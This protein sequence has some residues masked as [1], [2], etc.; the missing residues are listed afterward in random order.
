M[1]R[2]RL[3]LCAAALMLLQS[4]GGATAPV[5]TAPAPASSASKPA[6]ASAALA[7]PA[8]SASSAAKAASS[9]LTKIVA[10]YSNIFA[11]YLPLWLA[12]D[13]GQFEKNG[14]DV[15]TTLIESIKGVPALLSGEVQFAAIGGPEQLA[16]AAN[17]G[18]VAVITV[19]QPTS[20]YVLMGP[21]SMKTVPDLKG[22]KLGISSIG[23]A[24]D[25]STR[26]A[27]LK[28]GLDPDKDVTIVPVGSLTNR[29]AA[30]INGATDAGIAQVPETLQL[31]DKG[32]RTLVDLSQTDLPGVGG[33]VITRRS[34]TQDHRDVVQRYVDAHIAAVRIAK[35]DRART[36][37]T[38]KKYM[39][40]DDEKQLNA[41]YEFYAVKYLPALPAPR[42]D[43]FVGAQQIMGAKDDKVRNYNRANFIDDSFV[44][45]A[46]AR[47]LDKA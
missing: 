11:V 7:K 46:A 18:D 31:E 39:K 1:N 45:S 26:L 21:A 15:E 30:L 3:P 41:T 19:D 24:A 34:Y 29:L 10:S 43:D 44:K 25:I 4:C 20:A 17:G 14:L 32:F 27:L 28:F 40:I 36:I 35:T 2:V 47:G 8:A 12:K 37:A 38:L 9:G 5:S 23:G 13:T 6:E 42:P 33:G 16:S 22:K